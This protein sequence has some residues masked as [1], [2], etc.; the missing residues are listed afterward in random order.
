VRPFSTLS[1]FILLIPASHAAE[2][3]AFVKADDLALLAGPGTGMPETARLRRGTRL[4]VNHETGDYYAVQPPAGSVSWV[5]AG[6]VRFV[7]DRPGG[8][9][10]FPVAAVVDANGLAKLKVGKVGDPKPLGV[11]RTALPDG[12]VLTVI[13]QRVEQDGIKWYPV[14][15]PEDDFRYVAKAAVELG[16]AV[17]SKFVVTSPNNGP[18]TP[19]SGTAPPVA[20]VPGAPAPMGGNWN[21]ATWVEAQRAERAGELD[22]A[23]RL[24][25]DLAKEMNQSGGTEKLAE[26]CYAR[27][28]DIREKRRKTGG[29]QSQAPRAVE[30][31]PR[32]ERESLTV[33]TASPKGRAPAIDTDTPRWEGP[34]TLYP[35]ALRQNGQK[36]Y[37]LQSAANAVITYA[38]PGPGLDLSR[39]TGRGVSLYG[40]VTPLAGYP[41]KT[42]M[43][44]TKVESR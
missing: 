39:E 15:A 4:R 33:A 25:L 34:G 41:G 42:V 6:Y 1:L 37:A 27:V 5:R 24:Y 2:R 40:T 44:V 16:A 26:D 22:R 23:E 8:P 28:H 13:G 30:P 38:M 29:K 11:E 7:P 32:G 9:T 36:L 17:E 12:T 10:V 35:S 21:H 31:L 19:V 3:D 20:S 43:T 14:A 18:V